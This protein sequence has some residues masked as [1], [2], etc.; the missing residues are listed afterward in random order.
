MRCIAFGAGYNSIIGLRI[1]MST[2]SLRFAATLHSNSVP[3]KPPGERDAVD[4][5]HEIAQWQS[6]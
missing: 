6:E 4:L 5:L 1:G 2:E 3:S